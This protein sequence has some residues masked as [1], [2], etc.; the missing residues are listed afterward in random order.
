MYRTRFSCVFSRHVSRWFRKNLA[1]LG[2]TLIFVVSLAATAAGDEDL[3]TQDFDR[4]KAYRPYSYANLRI[5]IEKTYGVSDAFVNTKA[6]VFARV[7]IIPHGG[8]N[9]GYRNAVSLEQESILTRTLLGPRINVTCKICSK[10]WRLNDNENYWLGGMIG[11]LWDT[12]NSPFNLYLGFPSDEA[13]AKFRTAFW[14]YCSVKPN[15]KPNP[16]LNPGCNVYVSVA[17]T[18]QHEIIDVHE[19]LR[20]FGPDKGKHDLAFLLVDKVDLYADP[21]WER[22]SDD[23]MLNAGVKVATIAGPVLLRLASFVLTKQ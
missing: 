7:N 11:D 5:F 19:S 23:A 22:K 17:G 8:L 1:I 3:F 2:G 14:S 18:L 9:P 21:N 12:H 4:V 20:P 10:T 6:K 16:S 13:F 15:E